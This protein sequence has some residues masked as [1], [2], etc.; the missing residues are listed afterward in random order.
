MRV[1]IL[2][3]VLFV[4]NV[5]KAK[6]SLQSVFQRNLTAPEKASKASQLRTRL[7]SLQNRFLNETVDL[8]EVK[9][10]ASVIYKNH[11]QELQKSVKLFHQVFHPHVKTIEKNNTKSIQKCT[12]RQQ[13]RKMGRGIFP[14]RFKV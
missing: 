14:R 4:C 7:D 13:E 1:Q 9:Q 6:M 2:I 8:S 11:I 10:H 3:A 12:V 5:G